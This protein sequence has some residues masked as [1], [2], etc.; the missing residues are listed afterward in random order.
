MH[1]PD[2]RGNRITWRA[3]VNAIPFDADRAGIGSHHP[4]CDAQECRLPSAILAQ[5]GVDRSRSNRECRMVERS[6]I[7]KP[8]DDP[9]QLERERGHKP[10][11]ASMNSCGIP[12][13]SE[14]WAASAR[15]PSVSVA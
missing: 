15:T 7:A 13:R 5:E 10:V 14:I 6:H 4:E 9:V 3:K 2:S 11:G 12:K 8:L 1:H